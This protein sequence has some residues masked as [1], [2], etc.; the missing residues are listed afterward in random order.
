MS[1]LPAGRS[2]GPGASSASPAQ[3]G[4][5]LR[6][7]GSSATTRQRLRRWA[8]SAGQDRFQASLKVISGIAVLRLEGHLGREAVPAC[9]S[10]LQEALRLRPDQVVLDMREARVNEESR[11][12]LALM[13]R[14]SG[15]RGI[16]LW[17]AGPTVSARAVLRTG[18]DV[19]YRVFPSARAALDEATS[20]ARRQR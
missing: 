14:I 3:A 6:S 7:V 20:P 18:R 4:S 11:P 17:L 12:L 2:A 9:R 15:R 19:P 16:S 8:G 1:A 5:G 10:A 13:D